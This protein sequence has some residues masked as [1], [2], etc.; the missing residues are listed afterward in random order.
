MSAKTAKRPAKAALDPDMVAAPEPTGFGQLHQPSNLTATD[1]GYNP[2]GNTR[3][4]SSIHD[5]PRDTWGV[6]RL[7]P[8]QLNRYERIARKERRAHLHAPLRPAPI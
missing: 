4:T 6:P 3:W 1:L 7:R 8:L 5:Q 2:I